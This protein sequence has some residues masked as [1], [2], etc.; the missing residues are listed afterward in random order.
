[1]KVLRRIAT[2]AAAGFLLYLIGSYAAS[3]VRRELY[4]RIQKAI[5]LVEELSPRIDLLDRW[6]D[7]LNNLSR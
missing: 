4:R 2:L 5:V 6:T 3:R 1:M 7:E